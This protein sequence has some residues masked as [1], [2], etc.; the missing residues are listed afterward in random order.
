MFSIFKKRCQK[1]SI[2]IQKSSEKH[3]L[4][5]PQQ[6]FLLILVCYAQLYIGP[7]LQ[8]ILLAEEC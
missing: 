6:L 3:S 8:N 5:M 4:S 2:N 1:Q 7:L